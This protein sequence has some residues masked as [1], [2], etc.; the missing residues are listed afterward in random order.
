MDEAAVLTS[1]SNPSSSAAVTSGN[2]FSRPSLPI[3][4][5]C[6]LSHAAIPASTAFLPNGARAITKK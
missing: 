1:A 4:L 3:S 6:V 5:F 2:S